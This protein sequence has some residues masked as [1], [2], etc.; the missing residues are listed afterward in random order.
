MLGIT[1][2]W[3]FG[4][5]SNIVWIYVYISQL[6]ENYINKS[7][8]NLSFYFILGWFITDSL[9]NFSG[10]YKGTSV[11]ILY[12]SSCNIIFDTI[13]ICQYLYYKFYDLFCID[14]YD[15]LLENRNV[16]TTQII[17]KNIFFLL[18]TIEIQLLSIYLFFIIFMDLIINIT[19]IDKVIIGEIYGWIL[20]VILF[21]S[22]IFQ[23]I[24]HYKEKNVKKSSFFIFCII[25]CA[26]IL[27]LISIL[28]R[29]I[30]I[31]DNRYIYKNIQWII[32]STITTLMDLII[33]YQYYYFLND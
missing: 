27:L 11:I 30:D 20:C 4:I 21:L 6:K 17:F 10:Y 9:S 25:I 8:F 16:N 12:I 32:A 33:I 15:L 1:L 7:D 19:R 18:K 26:N 29:L 2:S 23:I 28:I 14:N 13:F 22:R 5:M 3:C 31:N 24:F